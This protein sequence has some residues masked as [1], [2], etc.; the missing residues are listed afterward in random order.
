MNP[1]GDAVLQVLGIRPP[2]HFAIF[3]QGAQAFNRGAQFHPV[4]GGV[5]LAAEELLLLIAVTQNGSPP[6][7][8]GVSETCSIRDELDFFHKR[9]QEARAGSWSGAVAL[10][11]AAE[12]RKNSSSR[13][14]IASGSCTL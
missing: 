11:R 4:I 8:A 2:L 14:R 9:G 13:S 12:F 3:L 7:G 1:G 6:P 10:S 5:G